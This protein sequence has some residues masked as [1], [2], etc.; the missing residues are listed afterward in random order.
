MRRI[1]MTLIPAFA[2]MLA[3]PAAGAAAERPVLSIELGSDTPDER[4]AKTQLERL[5]QQYDLSRWIFTTHIRIEQSARPHSHPVL[6]L[7]TRGLS[8]DRRA[9]AGFIHEQIHWFLT[10]RS[11]N[12]SEALAA[13]RMRYPK[14]PLTPAD[15]GADNP[16][17]T[18]LHLVVCELELE[19]LQ[20]VLG[21][22]GASAVIQDEIAFG[23]TGRGYHWIYQTVLDDQ[24]ALSDLIHR[25]GLALPGLSSRP[26]PSSRG[27]AR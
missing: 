15:G 18:Y 20:N 2:A 6:T 17:S 19:S 14:V 5:M 11:R 24:A 13:V 16:N 8:D 23:R 21:S 12:T 1:A 27:G 7:N 4:A 9:L 3:L 22:E 10:G 26:D 25:H